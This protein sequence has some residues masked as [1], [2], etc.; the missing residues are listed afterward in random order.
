MADKILLNQLSARFENGVDIFV[1]AASFEERCRSIAAGVAG[2]VRHAIV[3]RNRESLSSSELEAVKLRELFEGRSREVILSLSSPVE[4]ANVLANEVINQVCSADNSKVFI[5]ITTFT[6][7]QLLILLGLIHARAPSADIALGYTSAGEYSTNTTVDDVWLSRGVTNI[8]SVLGYS[9]LLSPSK[10]LHLMLLVGFESERA[11]TIIERME[12]AHIS[13][14]I[15]NEAESVSAKHFATNDKF[16]KKVHDF[17][18]Q[19]LSTATEIDT[20][21]FSCIDPL[22]AR[23]AILAHTAKYS[24]FNTVICPMNTKIS[25]VGAGLAAF[26]EKRL[27]LIYALPLEYNEKGYSTPGTSVSVFELNRLFSIR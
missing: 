12:P 24:D 10:R 19:Q 21:R 26:V 8:R 6:H 15:G 4:S 27:Q 9:G 20:F 17:V 13:L 7:E 2:K 25:T 11:Q 18:G 14:G 5:D 23:D 22:A 1:C 3:V 16:Y